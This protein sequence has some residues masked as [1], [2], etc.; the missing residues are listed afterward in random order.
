MDI[1]IFASRNIRIRN[2]Q[3]SMCWCSATK[4]I[5]A[6][7][8]HHCAL[9]A[10]L[11]SLFLPKPTADAS[12]IFIYVPAMCVCMRVCSRMCKWMCDAVCVLFSST[13]F[14]LKILCESKGGAS[15]F[16]RKRRSPFDT[17][18]PPKWNA[19]CFFRRFSTWTLFTCID[20]Y[21]HVCATVFNT[22]KSALGGSA[23]SCWFFF[24]LSFASRKYDYVCG[25]KID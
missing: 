17:L 4:T 6:E 21:I 15:F 2:T 12:I 7:Y 24:R 8:I 1:A 16:S 11:V 25:L 13:I 18:P 14:L 22:K 23:L 19:V 3:E 10:L 9:Y 5:P 20:R